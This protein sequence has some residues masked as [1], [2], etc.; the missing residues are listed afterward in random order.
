[1]IS[2]ASGEK[3]RSSAIKRWCCLA[4]FTCDR[5]G[6]RRREAGDAVAVDVGVDVTVGLAATDRG[7]QRWRA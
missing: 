4:A 2:A 1:M 7:D 6:E 3:S 5:V